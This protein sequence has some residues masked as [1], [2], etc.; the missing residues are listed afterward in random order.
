M[1]QYFTS[2]AELE[3]RMDAARQLRSE[4]LAA[5]GARMIRA[6]VRAV[7]A[8]WLLL[9]TVRERLRAGLRIGGSPQSAASGRRQT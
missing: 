8:I 9:E 2:R 1:A 5:G 3:S 7:G 4:T 6:L